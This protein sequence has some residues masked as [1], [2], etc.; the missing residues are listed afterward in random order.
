MFIFVIVFFKVWLLIFPDRNWDPADTELQI[1]S[2][3]QIQT[4]LHGAYFAVAVFFNFL[5]NFLY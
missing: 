5:N 1:Q 2:T 4:Q 3:F